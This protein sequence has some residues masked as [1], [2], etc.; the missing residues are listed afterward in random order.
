[1]YGINSLRQTGQVILQEMNR[2]GESVTIYRLVKPLLSSGEQRDLNYLEQVF[3][4]VIDP[5]TN[6]RNLF[7]QW[8]AQ[9][10]L[11]LSNYKRTQQIRNFEREKNEVRKLLEK[12]NKPDYM[13][14]ISKMKSTLLALE[15][16][17][18]TSVRNELPA[19]FKVPSGAIDVITVEKAQPF[20]A[21]KRVE[22]IFQNASGY[23]KIMD[24]YVGEHTLDFVWKVP[25]QIHVSILTSNIQKKPQFDA[26]YKRIL[27]E[28]QGRLEV[29]ICEPSEFHDRYI[30][31]QN[32]LWQSG[33]S[34]KDLGITKWGILAKIGN[35][36]TKTEIEK[37]FDDLWKS[38]NQLR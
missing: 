5:L 29:R 12:K 34:L 17:E 28:R 16:V 30:I 25:A 21:L 4:P 18:R 1:M 33:P 8:N 19:E 2:I 14:L 11:E 36:T 13:M 6:I 7:I 38:S 15:I 24:R 35:M 3:G 32:E 10:D 22:S 31:T 26:A 20:A 37:K 27:K 9:C 23:V